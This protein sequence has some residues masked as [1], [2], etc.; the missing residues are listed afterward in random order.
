V[1]VG[2]GIGGTADG[3]MLLSKRA[4]LRPLGIPHPDERYAQLEREILQRVNASGIGPQGLGGT[5][6]ALGVHIE[7]AACH[8]A[9]LPVAVTLNCHAVRRGT[10]VL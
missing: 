2:V 1:I 7:Y 9:S 10:V 5:V 6:T 8:L 4:L 3:A